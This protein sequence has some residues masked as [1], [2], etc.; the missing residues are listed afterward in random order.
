MSDGYEPQ[1]EP[2]Q[3]KYSGNTEFWDAVRELEVGEWLKADD[4][5]KRATVRSNSNGAN[6]SDNGAKKFTVRTAVD[7]TIW[8]GRTQ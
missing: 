8:I 1:R 5:M 6:V 4:E 7:D 2:P 3:F